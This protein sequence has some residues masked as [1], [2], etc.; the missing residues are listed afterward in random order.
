[1]IF[2]NSSPTVFFSLTLCPL[3]SLIFPHLAVSLSISIHLFIC[4][5]WSVL[6]HFFPPSLSLCCCVWHAHKHQHTRTHIHHPAFLLWAPWGHVCGTRG[7]RTN[8]S[9]FNLGFSLFPPPSTNP[10]PWTH[11]LTHVRSPP[12]HS[13]P[14]LLPLLLFLKTRSPLCPDPAGCLAGQI[15]NNRCTCASTD[16]HPHAQTRTHINIWGNT[17][18]TYKQAHA[19]TET[20]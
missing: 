11:A 16:T 5:S 8:I 3:L 1:M 19:A 13:P 10:N 20:H 12:P 4:L 17:W 9:N 7:E 6:A 14:L 18:K 15:H 2:L